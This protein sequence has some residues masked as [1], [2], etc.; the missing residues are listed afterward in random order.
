MFINKPSL[1]FIKER[2]LLMARSKNKDLFYI[3]GGKIEGKETNA[4]A[5]AREVLEELGTELIKDTCKE[6]FVIEAQAHG[7]PIGVMCRFICF[8]G[9]LERE[10]IPS[11]EIEELKYLST[12]DFSYTPEAGVLILQKL[13]ELNLI[14]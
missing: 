1:V 2:K 13:N 11:S 12:A 5:L 4:E 6:L 14:D 3:P 9:E 7:K 8:S 10:P